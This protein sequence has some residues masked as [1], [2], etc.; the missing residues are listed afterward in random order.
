MQKFFE[1]HRKEIITGAGTFLFI[2]AGALA[3]IFM[4]PGESH[5]QK[6]IQTANQNHESNQELNQEKNQKASQESNQEPQI[7]IH[8]QEQISQRDIYVYITGAVK[9][10]G[11][12]KF[13]EGSRIF[14]VIEAAGGF[15]PKADIA[16]LNLAETF[17]DAQH[18]HIPLKG[19]RNRIIQTQNA[20]NN[21]DTYTHITVQ[22]QEQKSKS[23]AKS[24][25]NNGLVD[26]NNASE[27]EL[28]K[29]TGVGPAIAKR[30]YEYRQKNG[31]FKSVE[32]LIHVRGIGPAKLEKMRSQILIR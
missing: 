25:G 3:M 20:N 7:Q 22:P 12:Y 11:V 27:S 8:A 29:L 4:P 16:A 18:I 30:I 26:V 10:P 23:S 14:E 15:T 5:Q 17:T 6:Q 19:E 9:K 2:I 32:E 24:S 31:R 28:Q 21:A 13:P 1:L